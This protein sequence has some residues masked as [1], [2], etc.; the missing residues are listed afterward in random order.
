MSDTVL[1]SSDAELR[2]FV[3]RA[4][5]IALRSGPARSAG[6]AWGSCT[7]PRTGKL[8]RTV[9]IKV[10]PPELGYRSDIKSRFLR[11]AETAAQLNHPNIV[12]IYSVDDAGQVVYFVMAYILGQNLAKLLHDVGPL[13]IPDV[14][15]ILRD[16]ADALSYAHERGVIHRDIKPDNILID[17]ESGRPMVTDF[18]IARAIGGDASTKLTATGQVIG[19][20]EYMS[21]EQAG[22]D[23]KIDG[24]SD[25]YSLGVVAYQML[26]GEPPFTGN[27]GPAILVKHLQS[28]PT[29]IEQRRP[30][31]PPELARIV[32]TLLEKDPAARFS[33]AAAL[34]AA[35]DHTGGIGPSMGNARASG[36]VSSFQ[37]APAATNSAYTP[38]PVASSA[39]YGPPTH[40]TDYSLDA[41]TPAPETNW[42]AGMRLR[43]RSSAG[44]S[45]STRTSTLPFWY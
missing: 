6:A 10:L 20:P 24:R 41:Y 28:V 38:P 7:A 32:M 31:T 35:L 42:P 9:A 45:R 12:D 18:G 2:P 8:K 21:P 43:S 11:E 29:P 17:G 36:G 15:R 40:T 3:E 19:T 22:G 39:S 44:I 33:S 1:P 23:P 4:S 5:R 16:V 13:A 34:V 26:A 30:D 25:L 37:Y 27:S 14:Q